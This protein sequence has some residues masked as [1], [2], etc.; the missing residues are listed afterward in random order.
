MK[1]HAKKKFTALFTIAL[2]ILSLMLP[3]CDSIPGTLPADPA[4]SAESAD[5]IGALGS[6]STPDSSGTQDPAVIPSPVRQLTFVSLNDVHGYIEQDETGKGGLS[7][8]AYAI[9]RLSRYYDDNDDKTTVRDDII[10]FGN[11][12]MF[13]GTA[14]SNVT[15]GRAVIEAMN[16]M[17]FDGMGIG[18]HEFDW[19]LEQ[20][21]S[22]WDRDESNGEAAFPLINSNIRQ[23]SQNRLVGDVNENDGVFTHTIVEKEGVKIGLISVI[24]PC[25]NSISQNRLK[26][27]SFDSVVASVEKAALE[28][29]AKGVDL[30]SVNIHYGNAGGV[31]DYAANREIAALKNGQGNYLVDVIFNGHTHTLQAGQC[32][33]PD[34]TAVP[35][36]QGGGQNSGLS[37]V[38]LFYDADTDT[39]LSFENKYMKIDTVGNQYDPAV[40]AVIDRYA[41]QLKNQWQTLAISGVTVTHKSMLYDYVADIMVKALNADYAV[42]NN[43]G[44]RGNGGIQKGTSITEENLYEIIPFDNEVYYITI[45][46]S[47]LY[48]FYTKEADYYYFGQKS[49]NPPLSSLK[50]SD[51]EYTLA[52]I[53][54][55]YTGNYFTGSYG[56]YTPYISSVENTHLCLRDLLTAD[57]TLYGKAGILWDPAKGARIEK[58]NWK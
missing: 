23:K 11:G 58:Q 50:G 45:Q 43:G 39:V 24:G 35:V 36:V 8:T 15:K 57:V 44:L 42:S 17:G 34:G 37:Y 40:E 48:D 19:G 32:K 9:N 47:A 31:N 5:S 38:R 46:G 1:T 53:D 10:L 28:L 14:I 26:D 6:A 52:I 29:D 4:G 30:I 56:D 7:N 33:R 27:Y 21:L 20:I 13:Q 18:N 54:Y 2:L 22:Y 41:E 3:S 55:V 25:E 12:D 49:D 51:R 16:A